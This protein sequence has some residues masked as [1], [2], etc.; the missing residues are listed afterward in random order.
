M[1]RKPT[2]SPNF[3][4]LLEAFLGDYMPNSAGLSANTVKSY[5]VTFRLLFEYLYA[6]KHVCFDEVAFASLNFDTVNGFLNHL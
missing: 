4:D 3:I 2:Q 6:E 5:T 1:K